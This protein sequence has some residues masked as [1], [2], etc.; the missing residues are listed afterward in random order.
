MPTFIDIKSARA[1]KGEA[2]AETFTFRAPRA[3]SVQLV[4]D[5]TAWEHA[6][7]SLHKEADDVWRTT[8][9]LTPGRH[10]YR[11]LVDGQWRD[12]PNCEER[13][14]N[15]FGSQDDVRKVNQGGAGQER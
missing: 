4:G 13:A 3:R 8:V 11:Y 5:F 15:P 10:L 12:D 2:R 6:P 7:I 14:E 9:E 1:T